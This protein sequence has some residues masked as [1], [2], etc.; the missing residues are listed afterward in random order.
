MKCVPSKIWCVAKCGLRSH[1]GILAVFLVLN[2]LSIRVFVTCV[3]RK[4][5]FAAPSEPGL[6]VQIANLIK[7]WRPMPIQSNPGLIDHN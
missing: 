2:L 6:I 4:D 5:I 3:P 1:T 7:A